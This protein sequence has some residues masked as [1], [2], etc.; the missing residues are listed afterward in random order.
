MVAQPVNLVRSDLVR[1]PIENETLLFGVI[2]L[3]KIDNPFQ[4]SPLVY[5]P[6]KRHFNASDCVAVAN[7]GSE[8]GQAGNVVV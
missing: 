4:T 5:S 3:R 6:K 2:E 8:L 1:F 7:P